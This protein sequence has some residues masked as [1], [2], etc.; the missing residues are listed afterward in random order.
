[1]K[2]RE[3]FWKSIVG[4]FMATLL[5]I[6][7]PTS[8]SAAFSHFTVISPNDAKAQ[9]G[10]TY[11]E[12]SVK[13]WQYILETPAENNPAVDPTG[14]NCQFGQSG[15]V[16]FLVSTSGGTATRND[17][18]VPAGK[19]LF[20]PLLTRVSYQEMTDTRSEQGARSS[21][22]GFLNSA[23]VLQATI[24]GEE[25]NISLNPKT[26]PLRTRS[27]AGFFTITAPENNIFGG[28]PGQSYNAV[29]DGFYLLVAPL[30]PGPH[31]ITFGGSSRNF[32]SYVTY[33]LIVEEP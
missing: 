30:P 22:Q 25:V 23:K 17:C 13:W 12:L 33:N 9:T 32:E 8:G 5:L 19:F 21:I 15:S 31:T 20:F 18:V 2:A 11:A 14:A 27:P 6:A 24:D 7:A 3:K 26:T 1:M 16:F 10:M 28:I 4:V 29:S